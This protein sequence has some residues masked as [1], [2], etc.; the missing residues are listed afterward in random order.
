MVKF[1]IDLQLIQGGRV[2]TGL[3][4]LDLSRRLGL[5]EST[6]LRITDSLTPDFPVDERFA[7]AHFGPNDVRVTREI[8]V[9][10]LVEGD[11]LPSGSWNPK[12][13]LERAKELWL[14]GRIVEE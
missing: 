7:R 12:M 2:V 11:L 6:Y 13:T 3:G 5:T 1:V 9:N 10:A 8:D 4:A 14:A